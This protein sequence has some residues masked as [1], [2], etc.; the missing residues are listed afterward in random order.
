MRVEHRSLGSL[1]VSIAGLGT[2]NF[3]MRI[4]H[5]ASIDV[6]RAAY[7]EGV[8]FYDTAD[9]YSGGKSE[10]WLAEALGAA[11]HDVVFGTKFGWYEG[12]SPASA[13][14][15]IEGSLRR[16]QVECVGILYCHRPDPNVPL[17]ET[18]GAMGELVTEGKVREIGCS[19]VAGAEV[20]DWVAT[21]KQ[22]GV[23]LPACVEDQYNAVFRKP[24][25]EL[26][27]ACL[28]HGMAF[29]PFFPLAS[30][31]LTGKYRRGEVPDRSSRLYWG[32][33]RI[34][35][36]TGRPIEELTTDPAEAL[37]T[38][39]NWH[40]HERYDV[41]LAI[42]EGLDAMA[43]ESGRTMTELALGWLAAQP[44]VPTIIAG[45]T[46]V[47]QTRINA[48]ASACRLTVDE[49]AAVESISRSS[50]ML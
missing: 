20:D 39:M 6:I 29:V 43:R 49:V 44:S 32:L 33:Q 48:R 3:G 4:G 25:R 27:P 28:R 15:A 2:N 50:L 5:A 17:A 10:A 45:A 24:E 38:S 46:S 7:D 40:P 34:A 22:L 42:V 47:E 9:V 8:T 21:A 36:E 13:R 30:G 18:I 23:R 16:L 14:D 26:I 11:R 35:A 37:R 41:D 31:L 12:A 19:N 1:T